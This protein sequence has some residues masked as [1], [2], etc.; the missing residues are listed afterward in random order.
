MPLP[1]DI[2]AYHKAQTA[3]DRAICETLA[4]VIDAH[5]FGKKPVAGA[6]CKVWHRHP[7][8]FIEGNPI[9]GYHKLK[10]GARGVP[11][12]VRLMFWSGK[13]F[14][15]PGLPADP[16]KSKFKAAAARF[17]AADDIPL[18]DLKR[19]LKKSVEIQWDYKNI[20]KRKGKLVRLK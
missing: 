5:F 16:P 12:C 15:E 9:V 1:A 6:E 18:R 2:L 11:G 20:V 19:W 3:A 17:T 13:S 14:D 8:W 4:G 7:V 10:G